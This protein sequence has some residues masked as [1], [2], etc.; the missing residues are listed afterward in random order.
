[1][2]IDLV[3]ELNG[4]EFALMLDVSEEL[5]SDTELYD[6]RLS[7]LSECMAQLKPHHRELLR[8]RYELGES[9]ESIAQSSSQSVDAVYKMLRRIRHH[10]FESVTCQTRK[11]Q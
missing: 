8:R 10:L 2:A 9:V 3:S 4:S 1:M 6:A 11:P 5:I 7:A